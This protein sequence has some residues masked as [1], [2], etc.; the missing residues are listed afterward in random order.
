MKAKPHKWSTD[1]LDYLREITPGNPYKTISKMLNEKF[2]INLSDKAVGSKIKVLNLKNGIDG[3]F[4]KNN[5]PFNKGVPMASWMTPEMMKRVKATQFKAD[6]TGQVRARD[7][8]PGTERISADGYVEVRLEKAK[9]VWNYGDKISSRC[10]EMKH[11]L[12]WEKYHNK[13]VPEGHVVIFADGNNRNFDEDNLLLVSRGEL[14]KMNQH[15]LIVKNYGELTK[16][17]LN[18]AKLILA[19]NEVKKKRRKIK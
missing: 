1:E 4:Q 6:G 15:H 12:L 13:K 9:Q 11:V 16:T 14:L 7:R 19:K 2:N 3:R 18:V 8:K 10:W 17:G 5:S